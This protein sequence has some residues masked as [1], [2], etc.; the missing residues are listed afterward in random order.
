MSGSFNIRLL[1]FF[2]GKDLVILNHGF[3]KKTQKLPGKELNVA[4]ERYQEFIGR[5]K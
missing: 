4:L 1:G 2:N 3:I 5:N